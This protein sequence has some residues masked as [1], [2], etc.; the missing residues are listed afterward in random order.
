MFE[1][2]LFATA[3]AATSGILDAK[4]IEHRIAIGDRRDLPHGWMFVIRAMVFIAFALL[5]CWR[6]LDSWQAVLITP[7]CAAIFATVHRSALNTMRG[8]HPLYISPSN[9]YDSL[10]LRVSFG[11]PRWEL[12]EAWHVY[13]MS[14]RTL[15]AGLMA[16]AFEAAVIVVSTYIAACNS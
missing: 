7:A 6:G 15:R 5:Q 8:L 10:F 9:A 13:M 4:L 16:Y 14:R 3:I 2:V 11:L 12:V 1:L